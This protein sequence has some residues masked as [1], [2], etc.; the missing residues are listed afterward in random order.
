M[1]NDASLIDYYAKRAGEYE[2]IYQKPERQADLAA[3][4]KLCAQSL[5]RHD[6]LEIACGT[7]YWTQ[8]VSQ[9]AKSIIATDIND[10]VIQVARAKKYHCEVS[11]QQADVF[12]LEP[13]AKYNF[14]AGMAMHWWSHLRKSEIAKFLGGYHPLFRSGT[15]LMFMDNRFVADSSTPISHADA[16]GNTYQSRQLEDGTRHEVLKNFP[17]EDEVK[18]LLA[19]SVT[20]VHWTELPYYWFLTYRLK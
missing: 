13:L 10:E 7:G 15:L 8:P 3:L 1:P 9:T 6:V 4:K 19:N 11:F 12:N 14:T 17:S 16:E 18:N 20:D 2:R 5:A